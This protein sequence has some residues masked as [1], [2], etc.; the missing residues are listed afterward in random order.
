MSPL[1]LF[2]ANALR[3]PRELLE[4]F[5]GVLLLSHCARCLGDAAR[6][7]SKFFV[8]WRKLTD[9]T[10]LRARFYWEWFEARSSSEVWGCA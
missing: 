2:F 10:D 8:A 5:S 9:G 6:I 3:L 7:L 1:V 4:D